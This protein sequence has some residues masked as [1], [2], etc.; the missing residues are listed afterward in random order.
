M[1]ENCIDIQE[2]KQ[3]MKTTKDKRMF[4]RYQ[5]V[6]LHLCGKKNKD[7]AM[8]LGRTPQTI[9]SYLKAYRKNG[10]AGLELGHSPGAPKRLTPEQE[11]QVA[12][13]VATKHPVDVGFPAQY[14]WTAGL[15]GQWI[16]REWD[17]SYTIKGI[18]K[19]LKR[20]GFSYTKP[21]YTLA[22]ADPKK[23]EAFRETF[24]EL[25]KNS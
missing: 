1:N 17:V 8:I 16:K 21:S 22:K 14:N 15:I 13:L 5:T 25:K 3:A 20:L 2:A 10:L 7:I 23:Q 18:T 24:N 4:E 12:E 6:Y 9:C 19:L 11:K